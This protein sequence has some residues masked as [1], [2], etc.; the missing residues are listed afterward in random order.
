MI[1]LPIITLRTPS[2]AVIEL[3][4]HTPAPHSAIRYSALIKIN[5]FEV[6]LVFASTQP[7]VDAKSNLLIMDGCHLDLLGD[8]VARAAEFLARTQRHVEGLQ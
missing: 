6:G 8:Y 2:S 3:A 7:R 1:R 4:A 5:N